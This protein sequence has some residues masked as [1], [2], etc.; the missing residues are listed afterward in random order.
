MAGA[1]VAGAAAV[2]AGVLGLV[3]EG[4]LVAATMMIRT[5]RRPKPDP[6]AVRILWRLGQ[7]LC[8][9]EE[10]AAEVV[11]AGIPVGRW[12]SWGSPGRRPIRRGAARMAVDSCVCP[13]PILVT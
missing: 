5:T 1:E 4:A 7:L 3:T 10:A 11:T 13:Q 9:G 2:V 8:G 12:H 6:S